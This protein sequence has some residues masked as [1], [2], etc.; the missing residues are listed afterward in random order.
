MRK[1][2]P[3]MVALAIV[4][5]G[6]A[7]ADEQDFVQVSHRVLDGRVIPVWSPASAEARARYKQAFEAACREAG[8]TRTPVFRR[9]RAK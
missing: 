7:E 8:G 4:T 3:A 9:G 1:T 5:A 6:A 2:M